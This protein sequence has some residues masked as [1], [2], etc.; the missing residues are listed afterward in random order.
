[1]TQIIKEYGTVNQYRDDVKYHPENL[2][3]Q[4]CDNC[5]CNHFW[6]NGDYERAITGRDKDKSNSE[7]VDIIR[8]K[9]SFCHENYSV[10]PSMIPL[11]RWYLWCM[12]QWVL[13]LVLNGYSFYKAARVS[14]VDRRTVSRW[15]YWLKDK[16]KII[17][18]TMCQLDKNLSKYYLI[19]DFY[20]SL[21][22][23]HHLSKISMYLHQYNLLVPYSLS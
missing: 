4:A 1:M 10:L 15:F 5:G 6:K 21:F 7:V 8:F 18:H 16:Y 23:C 22:S 20:S 9:C 14:G 11:F 17:Y 12:Q 13:L 2:K 19:K 3:P